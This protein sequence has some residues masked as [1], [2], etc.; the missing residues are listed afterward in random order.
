[1][2]RKCQE[3]ITLK[4]CCRF[5]GIPRFD[6]IN[7]FK[8]SILLKMDH[9]GLYCSASATLN[10]PGLVSASV[11]LPM[12]VDLT[13]GYE[14]GLSYISVVPTWL[15]IPDLW[16]IHTNHV[17]LQDFMRL[18]SV[19][20]GSK[21]DVLRALS[22]QLLEEYGNNMTEA[23]IKIFKDDKWKLRLQPNSL[24]ELSPGLSFI[25]GIPEVIEN[26]TAR[27]KD[28]PIDYKHYER[29][30]ENSIY[31][32]SCDQCVQNF[33]TSKGERSSILNFVHIPNANKGT[34]IQHSPVVNYVKL[35]GSL[36]H[37]LSFTLYNHESMPLFANSVDLYLLFHIRKVKDV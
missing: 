26:D 36:L 27:N 35:E 3:H 14:I 34:V 37:N 28:Y 22:N 4:N 10:S 7:A 23:R 6:S 31:Y 33:V 20:H 2:I 21:M 15:N 1:M 25:L 5:E 12:P 16:F 24:L 17:D 9:N 18:N 11:R 8:H 29:F 30:V 19:P 32:V 13:N